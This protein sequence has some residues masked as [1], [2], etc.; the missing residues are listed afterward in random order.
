MKTNEIEI[1][2][3]DIAKKI[4]EEIA[5]QAKLALQSMTETEKNVLKPDTDVGNQEAFSA[6]AIILGLNLEQIV[7]KYNSQSINERLFK[8]RRIVRKAISPSRQSSKP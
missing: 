6:R 8:L 5:K 7:Q 3:D 1:I 2:I 4:G